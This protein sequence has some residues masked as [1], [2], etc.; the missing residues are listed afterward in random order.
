[1]GRGKDPGATVFVTV[2][3][4]EFPDLVAAVSNKKFAQA[5][6]KLGYRRLLV[7]YGRGHPPTAPGVGGIQ[8]DSY[9]YKDSLEGDI[10]GADLVIS[11]AGAGTILEVLRSQKNLLVVVNTLL[12]DNHQIEIANHF[13]HL[14]HLYYCKPSELMETLKDVDWTTRVPLRPVRP[15]LFGRFLDTSVMI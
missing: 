12:M 10:L 6:K 3:S 11:H 9:R 1:M 7:Q 13:Q 4:T 5:L 8:F 2:G 15:T 14:K